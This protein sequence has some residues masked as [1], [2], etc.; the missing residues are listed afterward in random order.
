MTFTYPAEVIAAKVAKRE[1]D[2]ERIKV[3][4]T[5]LEETLG[6]SFGYSEKGGGF[7][8]PYCFEVTPM[9][10]Q[11][12]RHADDTCTYVRIQKA[13]GGDA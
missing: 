4:E 11:A 12:P 8:C 10:E 1:A 6:V 2:K 3:L 7:R 9:G 13:L 5:L